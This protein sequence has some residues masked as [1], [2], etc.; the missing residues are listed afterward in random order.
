MGGIPE[1][2]DRSASGQQPRLGGADHAH[3]CRSTEPL[4]NES[5]VQSVKR[6]TADIPYYQNDVVLCSSRRRPVL[7]SDYN[8]TLDSTESDV[9]SSTTTGEDDAEAGIS[10]SKLFMRANPNR[11][12]L[13]TDTSHRDCTRDCP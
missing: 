9:W 6:L 12:P 11:K 8:N 10:F 2:E 5:L 1:E 13:S 3:L 4:A 7:F